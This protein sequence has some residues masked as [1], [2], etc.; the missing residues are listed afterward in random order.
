M[1]GS[2]LLDTNVLIALFADET[3]VKENLAQAMRSFS[4]A[5]R[6][7]S[8]TTERGDRSVPVRISAGLT[9]W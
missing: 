6:S 4:H 8:F 3:E 1:A 9:R 5:L 2:Y 7:G